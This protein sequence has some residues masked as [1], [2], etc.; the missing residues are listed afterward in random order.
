M[1]AA[2]FSD[3]AG[4]CMLPTSGIGKISAKLSKSFRRFLKLR[5]W[6]SS[7]GER[8]S[9]GLLNSFAC[10]FRPL[11]GGSVVWWLNPSPAV[12]DRSPLIGWMVVG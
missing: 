9:F 11:L 2:D 8:E 4:H 1:R 6:F 5:S 3:P 12:A 10:R 7:G